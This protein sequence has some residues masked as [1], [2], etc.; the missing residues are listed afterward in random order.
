MDNSRNKDKI[1]EE[2][3]K[4]WKIVIGT[5]QQINS[6]NA[7]LDGPFQLL[8]YSQCLTNIPKNTTQS[9]INQVIY[10]HLRHTQTIYLLI[11]LLS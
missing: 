11:E 10:M 7:L 5:Q 3:K 2:I 4:E 1:I 9:S 6:L 8:P